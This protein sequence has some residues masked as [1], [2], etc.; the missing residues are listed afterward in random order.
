M[1][2]DGR[3]F[4]TGF[5]IVQDCC[6]LGF[7]PETK[8]FQVCSLFDVVWMF[9]TKLVHVCEGVVRYPVGWVQDYD[10]VVCYGFYE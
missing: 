7:D 8:T 5:H 3:N 9:G 1:R 4:M 10:L 6:G 2:L